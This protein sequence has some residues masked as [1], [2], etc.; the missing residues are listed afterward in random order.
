M[1]GS[2]RK[3][4]LRVVPLYD[5]VLPCLARLLFPALL[6]SYGGNNKV[7]FVINAQQCRGGLQGEK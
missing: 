3:Q 2:E 7:A 4:V 5:D 1:G 6:Y